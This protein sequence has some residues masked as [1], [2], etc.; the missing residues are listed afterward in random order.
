MTGL[1][2][3]SRNDASPIFFERSQKAT[4]IS[5]ILWLSGDKSLTNFGP[6]KVQSF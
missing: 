6:E 5:V 1:A 4:L 3:L 2:V